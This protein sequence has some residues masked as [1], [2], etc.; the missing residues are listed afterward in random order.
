MNKAIVS[1]NIKCSFVRYISR[2]IF[3][4]YFFK[5][6]PGAY[7]VS[8]ARIE[9]E[10]QWQAYATAAATP[11]LSRICDL[12]AAVCGRIPNPLSKARG[13]TRILTEITLG[14]QPAEPLNIC[15]NLQEVCQK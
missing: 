4:C 13:W 14:P 7:G 3:C 10:L 1:Q 5:A 12:P 6:A 15:I 9:S 2:E 8:Q 11:D